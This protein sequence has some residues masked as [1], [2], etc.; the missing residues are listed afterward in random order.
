MTAGAA[1]PHA[2]RGADLDLDPRVEDRLDDMADPDDVD[3]PGHA[4]ALGSEQFQQILTMRHRGVLT[5]SQQDRLGAVR[6]AV[7]GCGSIGGAAVEPLVRTGFRDLVLADPGSYALS[8]LNRQNASVADL[9]RNKSTVAAERARAINPHVRLLVEPLGVTAE[10]VDRLLLDVDVV[11]DGIDVTT[12]AGLAAKGLLHERAHASRL[13]L[14]TGW[15]MSGTQYV[16]V[17][18]YSRGDALL[19]GRLTA[20]EMAALPMWQLLRQLVPARVVP[21]DM[22]RIVRQGLSEPDF[23]FPQLASAADLFGVLAVALTVRLATGERV[24]REVVVDT[25][26]VTSR[27]GS[28]LRDAVL[29]PIEAIAL[30]RLV[31]RSS[32]PPVRRD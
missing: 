10:T 17:H 27:L 28:R 26:A 24:P 20:Q 6:V 11:I 12:P 23:T 30:L 8:N 21:R 2:D 16:Q 7:L 9:G 1:R 31:A 22:I 15:D 13:P 3:D 5:Q 18:D 4:L 29:R 19:R 32:T 25:H 14:V